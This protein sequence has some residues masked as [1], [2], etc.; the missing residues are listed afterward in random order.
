MADPTP[1]QLVKAL[2]SM[3]STANTSD[4]DEQ[5]FQSGIRDTD[6]YK[7]FLQ[8]YGEEPDLDAPEYDYRKAWANGIRP[9]RYPYDNNFPH[10]PSA[11]DSGEMLKS[12]DHPTAWKEHFMRQYGVNPDSLDMLDLTK[13]L[14]NR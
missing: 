8:R 11:L 7:S 4:F 13:M 12:P 5:A 1:Q 14:G 9:E 10:W 3:T 6:W 2:T